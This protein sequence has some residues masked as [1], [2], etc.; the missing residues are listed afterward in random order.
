MTSNAICRRLPQ[1]GLDPASVLFMRDDGPLFRLR[2]ADNSIPSETWGFGGGAVGAYGAY[3]L[4]RDGAR[5]GLVLVRHDRAQEA[6]AAV[7][8]LIELLA[9]WGEEQV[10]REPNVVFR[11]GEGDYCAVG[12]RGAYFAAAFLAPSAGAAEALLNAALE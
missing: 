10:Q 9:G 1:E 5:T 8:G 3:G 6:S 4:R 7:G 12:S 2:L 11:A